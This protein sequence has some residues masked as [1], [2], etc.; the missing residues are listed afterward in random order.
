MAVIAIVRDVFEPDESHG[1]YAVAMS[2]EVKDSITFSLRQSVWQERDLPSKGVY[3]VLSDLRR[4]EDGWRVMSGRFLQ[5]ADEQPVSQTQS[6]GVPEMRKDQIQKKLDEAKRL[7]VKTSNPAALAAFAS[8]RIEDALTAS[9]PGGIEASEALG[10]QELVQSQQL[11]KDRLLKH[12]KQ[13]EAAGF[14]FGNE[15]DDVFIAVKLPAGWKKQ[16]TDHSMWSDLLDDKG[17]RRAGIFYKAAFYDR[18]GHMSWAR[19]FS[20][21]VKLEG[22]RSIYDYD[23]REVGQARCYAVVLDAGTET[24][25]TQLSSSPLSGNAYDEANEKLK[26]P[27]VEEAQ[28]WLTERYPNWQDDFAHWDD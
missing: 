20:V 28:Q 19:R 13:L 22:D 23:L 17:R 27:L 3:V 6:K 21:E 25:R 15:V 11:P 18:R 26:E 24:Y 8:G 12:Q 2:D 9:M 7:G 5:P 14:V 10:Q 16:A 1:P 4:C